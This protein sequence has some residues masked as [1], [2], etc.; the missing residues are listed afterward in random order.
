MNLDSYCI[1]RILSFLD[2]DLLEKIYL[3]NKKFK[4]IIDRYDLFKR[5][6]LFNLIINRS[7]IRDV[8][9]TPIN[10]NLLKNMWKCLD[11]PSKYKYTSVLFNITRDI[12]NDTFNNLYNIYQE[13]YTIT[14]ND[15]Y[16]DKEKNLIFYDC[17]Y[18]NLINCIF[19]NCVLHFNNCH[20]ISIKNVVLNN[21][22]SITIN[23]C[24]KVFIDNLYISGNTLNI[25]SLERNE[26]NEM[27]ISNT[28]INS[29][30]YNVI[31]GYNTIILNNCIIR[32]GLSISN[33]TKLY[34]DDKLIN[35]NDFNR[36]MFE[37]TEIN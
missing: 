27:I 29:L 31:I 34:V 33:G 15:H 21:P 11:V 1:A 28:C 8:C 4:T 7:F 14:F 25:I 37:N 16:F 2:F 24:N 10:H 19:N 18:I 32:G 30:C 26:Y 12:K 3:Y 13:Y 36:N 35:V 5:F 17:D 20:N 9:K 22:L 23:D 6:F